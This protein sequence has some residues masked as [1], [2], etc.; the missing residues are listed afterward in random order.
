MG[1]NKKYN[2]MAESNQS[3]FFSFPMWLVDPLIDLQF[4]ERRLHIITN[5]F[6]LIFISCTIR[7]MNAV[8][9]TD[10]WARPV[11][12][13]LP[14][15]T[16]LSSFLFWNVKNCS[17]LVGI[18][19]KNPPCLQEK[20][21][22]KCE[23]YVNLLWVLCQ[24]CPRSANLTPALKSKSCDRNWMHIVHKILL[25][26]NEKK[27]SAIAIDWYEN[28]KWIWTNKLHMPCQFSSKLPCYPFSLRHNKC[29]YRT[30]PP[31]SD[32]YPHLPHHY[33]ESLSSFSFWVLLC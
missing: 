12:F 30:L 9:S 21:P 25:K 27:K 4:C 26:T 10:E 2:C 20:S 31:V 15:K 3:F 5:K 18:L 1:R 8:V 14:N 32:S 19:S 13:S 33:C 17:N 16:E 7:T 6:H 28:R 29:T 23:T 22:E 24:K 11:R